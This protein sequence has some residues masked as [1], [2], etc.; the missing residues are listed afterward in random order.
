MT[1][2]LCRMP[3]PAEVHALQAK[4]RGH[5]RFVTSRQ[6]QH[7]AVVADPALYGA[8]TARA[9]AYFGYQFSFWYRHGCKYT[10][11]APVA[12]VQ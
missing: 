3:I 2:D 9:P 1:H 10:S 11:S 4:V 7:R 6:P 8:R 12:G 5:Q